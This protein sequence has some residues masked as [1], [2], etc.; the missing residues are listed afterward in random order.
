M[1]HMSGNDE[2]PSRNF[3]DSSQ[4]TNWILDSRAT[5]HMTPEVSGFIT[6]LLEETDRNIEVADGHHVMEKQKG[7]V[8]IKMCD[9]NGDSFIA[10]LHNVLLASYLRNRLFS[11]ITVMNS[12]HTFLFHK[13]FCV[14]YFGAK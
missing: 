14:V 2:C 13:G 3:G 10:T 9:N 1:A 11:I 4:L 7:Q 12:G 8:L 6:G 5:C